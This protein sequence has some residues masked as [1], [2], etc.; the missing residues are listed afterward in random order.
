MKRTVIL[1]GAL[2]VVLAAGILLVGVALL[3]SPLA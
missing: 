3:F 2:T 1:V